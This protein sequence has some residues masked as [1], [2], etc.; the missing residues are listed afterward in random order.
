MDGP[1][2]TNEFPPTIE[3]GAA[4]ARTEPA[5]PGPT[6]ATQPPLTTLPETLDQSSTPLPVTVTQIERSNTEHDLPNVLGYELLEVLGRGGMGVV[7]KA[8]Q[9]SLKRLVALKMIR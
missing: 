2:K 3:Q 9:T 1:E 6:A 8:R 7:Y 4:L 5:G